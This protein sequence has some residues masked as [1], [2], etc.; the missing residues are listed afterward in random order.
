[1]T[2]NPTNTFDEL[3]ALDP[4]VGIGAGVRWKSPARSRAVWHTT[5]ARRNGNYIFP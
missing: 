3:H 1:M 5:G 2:S 4:V